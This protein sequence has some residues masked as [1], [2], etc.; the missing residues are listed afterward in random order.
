MHA[1]LNA[2]AEE[3]ARLKA[4]GETTVPVSDATLD[5]LRAMVRAREAAKRPG[6]TSEGA[7]GPAGTVAGA[8]NR[9]GPVAPVNPLRIER[10]AAAKVA[11]NARPGVGGPAPVAAAPSLPPPPVFDLPAGD[12]AERRAALTAL[13]RE[14]PVCAARVRPGL[15]L[16]PGAGA[17]DTKVF[18]I[19]DAPGEEEET[20]GEPFA[21]PA[22]ELLT[23]MLKGMGLSREAVFIAYLVCWRPAVSPEAG[24]DPSGS[25]PP[26]AEEIAF[27]RPFLRAALDIVQP[28]LVVALGATAAQGL[29]GSGFTTLPEMRGRWLEFGGRPLLVTYHPNYLLRSASN[30]AK[31]AVWEDLLKV[32][33]R[34]GLPISE[35]Q[36]GYYL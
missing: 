14:H 33:E 25:R 21:G 20:T 16:V 12:K 8:T 34:V 13:M 24:A 2:I 19:G 5:G 18:L 32:M 30:R 29:L 36:R 27:C 22:G 4:E 1:I 9:P 31:R 17:L 3:L 7:P 26:S 15:K 28:E 11:A 6:G 35:R 10:E 23:K